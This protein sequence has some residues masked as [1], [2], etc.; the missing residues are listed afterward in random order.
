MSVVKNSYQF[1]TELPTWAKGVIAV[2]GLA[3]LYFAGKS[4]FDRIKKDAATKDSQQVVTDSKRDLQM[5]L[6]SGMKLSYP[7]SNYAVFSSTLIAAF[8]G[9]GTAE[10]MV[11]SVFN[12]MKNEADVLQLIISFGLRTIKGGCFLG[13]CQDDVYKID[14]PGAIANEMLQSEK[15]EINTILKKNNVDYQF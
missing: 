15:D 5:L 2:G 4:V 13:F 14:L 7:V 10:T 3:I 8:N 1:Y 6:N 12:S 11:Y 9:Y